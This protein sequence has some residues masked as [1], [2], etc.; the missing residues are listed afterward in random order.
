MAK[1]THASLQAADLE[2]F[3]L[4][5]FN[6]MTLSDSEDDVFACAAVEGL[7]GPPVEPIGPTSRGN[8]AWVVFNGRDVGVFETWYVLL[9][10][11]KLFIVA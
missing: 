7:H 10:Y 3:D 11:R 4:T 6:D 9:T 2:P 8:R 5:A 1:K